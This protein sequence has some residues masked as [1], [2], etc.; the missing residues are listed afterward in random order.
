VAAVAEDDH[1]GQGGEKVDQRQEVGAQPGPGEGPVEDLVGLDGQLGA[2]TLLGAEALHDAD[3]RDALLDDPRVVPELLLEL[4]RHRVQPVGETGGRHREQGQRP[5]RE[6]RQEHVAQ[7]HDEDHAGEEEGGGDREG[8]QDDDEVDLLDVAVRPGHELA[9]L[10]AVVEREVELLQV[11]EQPLAQ[12]GLDPVRDAERG[13]AP[14]RGPEGL[15]HPDP[16]DAQRVQNDLVPVALQDALVDGGRGEQ[17][18]GQARRGPHAAGGDPEGEPAPLRA[19]GGS[20][21]PPA[22]PARLMLLL[23]HLQLLRRGCAR[24]AASLRPGLQATRGRHHDPE[25]IRE[26]PPVACVSGRV[27]AF[28]VELGDH[29]DERVAVVCRV[30]DERADAHA[31][32]LEVGDELTDLRGVATDD[33]CDRFVVHGSVVTRTYSPR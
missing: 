18:T 5:Q 15:D 2:L 1:E 3:P 19:E 17:R 20:H 21:E 7:D 9:G 22:V 16:E 11:G 12:V 24:R 23:Q 29:L 33:D 26:A 8:Q 31:A 6:H 13:V 32:G 30:A 4:E 27:G 28:A 14:R 10:R 25:A